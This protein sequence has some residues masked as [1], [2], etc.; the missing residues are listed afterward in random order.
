MAIDGTQGPPAHTSSALAN[1]LLPYLDPHSTRYNR[2]PETE[3]V[4][5]VKAS[6]L[7]SIKWNISSCP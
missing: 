4:F 3:S 1:Y 5:A 6:D 7:P 2:V